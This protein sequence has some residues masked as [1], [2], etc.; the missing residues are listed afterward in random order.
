MSG[1]LETSSCCHIE[2]RGL[3]V[4]HKFGNPTPIKG[5]HTR[6]CYNLF[7]MKNTTSK[8]NTSS[9]K[10]T[11]AAGKGDSPRPITKKY[12]ENYDAIDWKKK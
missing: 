8:S 12:W 1:W 3:W 2:L 10:K 11:S 7:Y 4:V 5:I 9:V 6:S